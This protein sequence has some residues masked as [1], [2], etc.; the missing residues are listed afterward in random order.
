M[1]LSVGFTSFVFSTDAT[2]AKGLLTFTPIGLP[3][4]EHV[5]LSWTRPKTSSGQ[6]QPLRG[7]CNN[8]TFPVAGETTIRQPHHKGAMQFHERSIGEYQRQGTE[9]PDSEG[10]FDGTAYGAKAQPSNDVGKHS[11]GQKREWAGQGNCSSFGP[12]PPDFRIRVAPMEP[13]TREEPVG[14]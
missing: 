12:F 5:C 7:P 3:P 14:Q 6:W 2:Q 11:A 13:I 4:I 1:A 10:Q 9:Q 8:V